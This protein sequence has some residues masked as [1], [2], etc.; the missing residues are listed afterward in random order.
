MYTN[1]SLSGQE[2]LC[3][4]TMGV[5]MMRCAVMHSGVRRCILHI[6][7]STVTTGYSTVYIAIRMYI[8]IL[9][10]I[11]IL[12]YHSTGVPLHSTDVGHGGG[13]ACCV[14][15]NC[16]GRHDSMVY[17]YRAG[18]GA[19]G[20]HHDTDVHYTVRCISVYWCTLVYRCTLVY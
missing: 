9:V 4:G 3:H 5:L 18:S 20:V 15:S 19:A 7:H 12:M 1:P 14:H 13:G 2:V 17:T 6:I 10:C 8:A 16:G 11:A